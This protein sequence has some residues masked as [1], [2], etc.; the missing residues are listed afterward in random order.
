MKKVYSILALAVLFMFTACKKDLNQND[1]PNPDPNPTP[2][3]VTTVSPT[4]DWSM[5]D[6]VTITISNAKDKLITISPVNSEDA[7][8]KFIGKEE[9]ITHNIRMAKTVEKISINGNEVAIVNRTVNYNMPHDFKSVATAAYALDFDQAN[10]DYI[11]TGDP[12]IIDYPVVMEAWFKTAGSTTDMT[13]LSYCDENEIGYGFGVLINASGNVVVRTQKGD[14]TT[15]VEAAGTNIVSDNEWHHVAVV[16][17][18]E[19]SRIVYLNGVEEVNDTDVS[20]IA[21]TEVNLFTIGR[22]GDNTPGLYYDGLIDEVRLWNTERTIGNLNFYRTRSVPPATEG[23]VGYWSMEEGSG[24]T[25]ANLTSTAGLDGPLTSPTWV[26]DIDT[27]G[28]GVINTEDHYPH[29]PDRAFNNYWPASP[30]TLAFEDL[31]P[32]MGDYD[33]NDMVVTYRFNRVTNAGGNLVEAFGYFSLQA[34]GASLGKAFGFELTNPAISQNDFSVYVPN[35]QKAETPYL[36]Y[37]TNGTEADQDKPVIIVHEDLP[38]IGNTRSGFTNGVRNYSVRL[39][40]V[41]TDKTVDYFDLQDWNPFFILYVGHSTYDRRRELH[42]PGDWPTS[43][44]MLWS[45]PAETPFF[46]SINDGSNYPTG[47][48]D[49]LLWYKTNEKA[50]LWSVDFGQYFPWGLDI[51]ATFQWAIESDSAHNPAEGYYRFTLKYA[52]DEFEPWAA[53]NGATNLNW[54]QNITD[55]DFIY[56]P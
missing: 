17:E 30:Y 14:A 38:N 32:S 37:N 43:K 21:P 18:A 34:A 50:I 36:S 16:F 52:Y 3:P 41:A 20:A 1:Q 44:A 23:L 24:T 5:Q 45:V 15:I 33:L 26:G 40:M 42:L 6:E 7:W 39:D 29:D 4:F 12:G 56:Q 51:P 19:D 13:L 10:S 47:G 49:G 28:D 55:M 22:W 11:Q 31:W 27:D 46:D 35:S 2:T 9:T 48:D 54:Y 8:L 25:T 53:S